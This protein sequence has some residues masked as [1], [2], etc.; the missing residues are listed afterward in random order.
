MGATVNASQSMLSRALRAFGYSALLLAV[1]EA[2]SGDDTS[3]PSAPAGP[4]SV[5]ITGISL[6]QGLTG[7]GGAASVLACDYKIGVTV[8]TT[9]WTL[10]PP[11]RC[12]ATLQCGQLRVSLLSSPAGSVL[13]TT[14]AAGNGVALDVRNL[15]NGASPL[16]VGRYLVQVELVDD[17]GKT[18]VA[19]DGSKGSNEAGFDLDELPVCS[20]S[21]GIGGA[22]GGSGAGNAGAS[23]DA[24]GGS[25]GD[26]AGGDGGA[27]DGGDSA[28]AAGIGG[29]AGVTAG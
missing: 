1:F 24:A 9:N 2:C 23:G 14:V 20:S 27:G 10:L 3:T 13:A 28:G 7:D 25:A 29:S 15:V 19:P 8:Q 6:G 22:G 12:G 4:A 17:A 16:T 11:G 5:E 26:G 21:P 18:Y